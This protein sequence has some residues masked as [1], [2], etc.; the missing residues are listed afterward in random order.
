[1]TPLFALVRKELAVLFGSP[2]AYMV[3]TMVGLVAALVFFEHLQIYHQ[4][5]FIYSTSTMGG[6]ESDTIPDY[7]NLREQVFFPVM[8]FLAI[9][10]IGL[11]PPV[12]MRMFAEERAR[13]TDELLTT[14]LLTPGQ[15]VL[16]KFLAT[17]F[18]V[19][20]MLAV[21]FVYPATSVWRAGL[22]VPHLLAVYLGLFVYGLGLASIGLVCSA[23]TSSQLVAMVSAYAVSF[24]IFDFGW[25]GS[26]VS[27]PAARV[28]EQLS[29]QPRFGSFAEGFV[30]LANVTYFV[31]M[32]VLAFA[33][34]RFSF[35]LRQV[36]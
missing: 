1:M 16:G 6:F 35:D 9:T 32:A 17:Y 12:T 28:L 18:F 24:V 20:L 25:M 19:A 27:E 33:I 2:V 22:G 10:L 21:S 34:A 5:L 36:R 3:L 11:I 15:I 7:I 14:T 8:D 4:T 29:M 26:F 30:S 23:Y 13:A 31:A